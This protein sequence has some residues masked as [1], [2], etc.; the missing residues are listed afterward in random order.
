MS[1]TVR[2]VTKWYGEQ[3]ALDHVTFTV[4]GGEVTGFLGP[5]GAGKSTMMKIITGFLPPSSGEV[6][7]D[8]LDVRNHLPEVKKR[9]GYLPEHNPLYPEMY[10]R[11]YLNYV[12]GLYKLGSHKKERV[13]EIIGL[14]GLEPE[15]HKKIGALS[16]GYRQRVG[17]AQAL[18]HDPDVL[19]LDEPTSGLDPN[20]IVEIRELI[21]QLG[22]EKTVLLSTH[23]MQE[24]EAICSRVIIIHKGRIIADDSEKSLVSLKTKGSFTTI[25]TEF[26]ESLPPDR[27]AALSHVTEIIPENDRIFTLHCE[28]DIREEIFHFAQRESLTLLG[29]SLVS[30]NLEEVFRELTGT[31]KGDQ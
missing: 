7:V 29:L 3:K 21:R 10:I 11:E 8:G 28:K 16:K 6:L 22:K 13:Q 18:L 12:A 9:I 15:L 1:V 5:N 14:T 4:S 26:K 19:I 31:M 2:D 27:L 30:Q 17:L 20:Q 25:R 23:I 24:V